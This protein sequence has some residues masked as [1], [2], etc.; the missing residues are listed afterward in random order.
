M[1][2]NLLNLKEALKE[3]RAMG[4][5]DARIAEGVLALLQDKKIT[6]FDANYILNH[7]KT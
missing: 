1:E 5:T 3:A 6:N 4:W 7:L 2:L